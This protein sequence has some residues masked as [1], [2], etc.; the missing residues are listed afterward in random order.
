MP[1]IFSPEGLSKHGFTFH[2]VKEWR[3]REYN[4]GRASGLDDFYRAHGICVACG[5][6]GEFVV[7]VRWRDADGDERSEK[8]PVAS[9]VQNHGLDNPKNWLTDVRKWDYL[10]EIC[11]ACKGFGH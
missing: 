9:L 4:A 11:D 1:R 8:G 3:E 7:G 5:G 2:Q 6:H 10:Y